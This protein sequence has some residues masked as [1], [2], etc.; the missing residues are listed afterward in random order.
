[1]GPDRRHRRERGGPLPEPQPERGERGF[2]LG[3]QEQEPA[4]VP[5]ESRIDSLH[6]EP[7]RERAGRLVEITPGN[8][9]PLQGIVPLL[10]ANAKL[11]ARR[12]VR[13]EDGDSGTDRRRFLHE[14]RELWAQLNGLDA[15]FDPRLGVPVGQ[16]STHRVRRG[17]DLD[18][19]AANRPRARTPQHP[20]AQSRDLE[21][22]IG[23]E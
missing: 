10:V 2:V 17:A 9:L 6:C 13:L 5:Q 20:A 11:E 21:R 3:P 18:P 8:D 22:Q 4:K 1:M 16:E 15:D 23:I 12:D 7:F 19:A 14:Q